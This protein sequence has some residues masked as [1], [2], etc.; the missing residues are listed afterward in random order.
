[1]GTKGQGILKVS[2]EVVVTLLNKALADEWLA[3]IQYWAG[4]QV[5]KG[6]MRREIAADLRVH[7]AEELRHADILAE[8]IIQLGGT[9]VI[10]PEAML[11]LAGG[12]EAP[13]NPVS[14]AIVAQNLRGEQHAV[15]YY[16]DVLEQVRGKDQVTHNIVIEI[17]KDEVE[18]EQ[19]LED[20]LADLSCD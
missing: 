5:I 3:A 7:M 15:L 6:R 18:H 16:N 19:D 11:K 12:Y 10:S 13:A 17:L 8:R 20:L 2:P 4:A 1:M 14:S 9:P